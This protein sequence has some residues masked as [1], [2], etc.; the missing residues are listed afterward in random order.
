MSSEIIFLYHLNRIFKPIGFTKHLIL[1]GMKYKK[2]KSCKNVLNTIYKAG[3]VIINFISHISISHF[4]GALFVE[5]ALA[6]LLETKYIQFTIKLISPD[7]LKG[8]FK[9]K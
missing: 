3:I 5:I 7:K 9:G 1:T 2:L 8:S 4:D 6:L